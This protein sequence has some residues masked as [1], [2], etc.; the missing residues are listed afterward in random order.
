[1]KN[2]LYC[3]NC[4]VTYFHKNTQ[5]K[6]WDSHSSPVLPN[7]KNL[8][9]SL[10]VDLHLP[11]GIVSFK[12][13]SSNQE[14]S[15]HRKGGRIYDSMPSVAHTHDNLSEKKY[16]LQPSPPPT[17]ISSGRGIGTEIKYANLSFCSS[18]PLHC[19]IVAKLDFWYKKKEKSV[20]I[21]GTNIFQHKEDQNP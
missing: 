10:G 3:T 18:R 15:L 6:H 5:S 9:F 16:I 20:T 21:S 12:I 2:S 19:A 14:I 13:L 11:L 8:I 17:T 4:I 7:M 1:M